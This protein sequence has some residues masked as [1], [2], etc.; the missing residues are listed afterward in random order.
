MYKIKVNNNHKTIVVPYTEFI[1]SLFTPKVTENNKNIKYYVNFQNGND[2]LQFRRY[3]YGNS[4][5]TFT[6]QD[7]Q[8]FIKNE[9]FIPFSQYP[10][11][12][13]NSSWSTSGIKNPTLPVQP[14][15]P[16]S[17][18]SQIIGGTSDW[19]KLLFLNTP[20]I[21]PYGYT[22]F[23]GG[24]FY[25]DQNYGNFNFHLT[26]FGS[27]M[28]NFA[29]ATNL[30]RG[31]YFLVWQITNMD[32]Q[33]R[34]QICTEQRF[35]SAMTSRW[36]NNTINQYLVNP[37]MYIIKQ[38][39]NPRKLNVVYSL[40][41]EKQIQDLKF[42]DEKFILTLVP[43]NP[44]QSVTINIQTGSISESI[45]L[46]NNDWYQVIINPSDIGLFDLTSDTTITFTNVK[47]YKYT[48]GNS[49]SPHF[50]LHPTTTSNILLTPLGIQNLPKNTIN[51]IN[52]FVTLDEHTYTDMYKLQD[53]T[54]PNGESPTYTKRN[55]RIKNETQLGN[56]IGYYYYQQPPYGL[57]Y[58]NQQQQY[59][60]TSP[61]NNE[62]IPLHRPTKLHK[63]KTYVLKTDVK[64]VSLD[65]TRPGQTQYLTYSSLNIKRGII[66]D[67]YYPFGTYGTYNWY[68]VVKGQSSISQTG[69][70]TWI[71]PIF[72]WY[73]SRLIPR[74][75]YYFVTGFIMN[76]QWPYSGLQ[77]ILQQKNM[78]HYE[79]D[80]DNLRIIRVSPV[81][82]INTPIYNTLY[83]LYL[84]DYNTTQN[85][86]KSTS[87]RKSTK[88]IIQPGQS[89]TFSV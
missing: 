36:Q 14:P 53:F 55:G 33:Q 65:S 20:V 52:D 77:N 11:L 48:F 45:T 43:Q 51:N 40:Y 18:S 41:Q 28:G 22:L 82:N 7:K 64:C 79:I 16:V 86:I 23:V 10:V 27:N 74:S 39:P 12:T 19:M 30:T 29:S 69:Y 32:S 8:S 9:Y 57:V 67:V 71:S 38:I 35:E 44:T 54:P 5:L 58:D 31:W 60:I 76:Y 6:I 21:I 49:D 72:G 1:K 4:P 13:Q 66:I 17:T 83:R 81:I 47:Y 85:L 80:V 46:S 2:E 87:T 75:S 62:R 84:Y 70:E 25:V 3:Y 78:Y 61:Q 50:I 24:W 26:Y 37:F 15:E 42:T 59:V 88:F 89:I 63:N 56:T 34:V 73:T 68:P